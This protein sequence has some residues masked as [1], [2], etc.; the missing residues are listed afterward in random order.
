MTLIRTNSA[1]ALGAGRQGPDPL[2]QVNEDQFPLA[3]NCPEFM[4]HSQRAGK[5]HGA[6]VQL[7][8]RPVGKIEMTPPAD[9]QMRRPQMSI[10]LQKG[11]PIRVGP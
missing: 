5:S 7:K 9:T 2:G 3:S 1:R 6:G 11:G 8:V 10:E 4:G